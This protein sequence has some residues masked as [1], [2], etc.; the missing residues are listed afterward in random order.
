MP[1]ASNVVCAAAAYKDN[2]K[3]DDSFR[4]YVLSEIR[5]AR[6]QT[7]LWRTQLDT[8]GIALKNGL[9]TAQQAVKELDLKLIVRGGE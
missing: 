7:E 2:F 5:V 9:I 1:V 4:E 3:E 8:V 6:I